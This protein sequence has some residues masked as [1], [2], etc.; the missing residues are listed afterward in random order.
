[1]EQAV[2]I[3]A[4]VSVLVCSDL[5]QVD[6]YLKEILQDVISNLTN[7]TWRVR[8]SRYK[9]TAKRHDSLLLDC[10]VMGLLSQITVWV[11]ELLAPCPMLAPLRDG[12][13]CLSLRCSSA[14]DH[15]HG[16]V[17]VTSGDH[18]IWSGLGDISI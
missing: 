18:V 7:N 4:D 3:R 2:V 16:I 15:C 6:K 8:E 12:F 5:S 17:V 14:P 9:N 13:R 11:R 10:A 1:M